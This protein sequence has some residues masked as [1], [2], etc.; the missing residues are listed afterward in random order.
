MA[1][2]ERH[3]LL[4][5][6]CSSPGEE[7]EP[8]EVSEETLAGYVQA[9]QQH[10]ELLT[11][12]KRQRGWTTAALE[13]LGV[14]YD[15]ERLTIPARSRHGVLV[16]LGR[17]L[18]GSAREGAPKMLAVPGSRRELFPPPEQLEAGDE[19]VFLCEGEPDA[20]TAHALGLAAVAVPG[21]RS[22]QREWRERFSDRRVCLVF[23]CDDPGRQLAAQVAADL[24]PVAREV[25][26]LDLGPARTNGFDLSDRVKDLREFRQ[27]PEQVRGLLELQAERARLVE[28]ERPGKLLEELAGFVRR[29]VVLGQAELDAIALWIV[30][31]H[32]FEAAEAT[33]YLAISSAEKASGKTRLLET[34][35]LVVASP[36]LTGRVTAAVLT[37]KVDAEKPTLLLDESDAAFNGE[38]E[39]AE[40][41]RGI[42]N[43][44]YRLGGR[45][46]V[47][48]P[49]GGGWACQDLSTF[50]PK[51]IAGLGV[52]PD[53]VQSRSIPIVLKRRLDEEKVQRF[54]R[55]EATAAAEA[56][57]D[58][59]A[60]YAAEHLAELAA[61]RPRLPDELG[62]RAQDVWE[63]LLA[64]A[65]LAAGEW[66]DRAR[67]AAIALS[68]TSTWEDDSLS[69]R[70][71][72]D[73]RRVFLAA[74]ADKL[75]SETDRRPGPDPGRPLGRLVRQADQR[76][77]AGPPPEAVL[78][79]AQGHAHRRGEPKRLRALDVRRCL[80]P[81]S[82]RTPAP[83]Q[84]G[85]PPRTR[86][87]RGGGALLVGTIPLEAREGLERA[88]LAVLSERQPRRGLGAGTAQEGNG[89]ARERHE[90]QAAREQLAPTNKRTVAVVQR[91]SSAR[92]PVFAF[93]GC[94][95]PTSC[96]AGCGSAAI[97]RP[98]VEWDTCWFNNGVPTSRLARFL[99]LAPLGRA[100]P[101]W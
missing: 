92:P 68:A 42:L 60:G 53:T 49:S 25:R 7:P 46:S 96:T 79:Q 9:L 36:W 90:R 1:L 30:H 33:P 27:T 74:G 83:G 32:A 10:D 76:E 40:A 35:E 23:D 70:L 6:V 13:R 17:Y 4:D 41:L 45:T 64:I 48:V 65:D 91:T 77:Q 100:G 39:Y 69:V 12:L 24:A 93:R 26:V 18:P 94:W 52:L 84:R 59:A 51:A 22:W 54:R 95:L 21:A 82:A 63:P 14:G 86:C 47:A 67:A 31:T 56:L 75:H 78:D 73:I 44:G 15:G 66:P 101:R 19:F 72:S 5:G 61:A 16:G 11:M 57:H 2:L 34:L 20:I 81:L 80:E 97:R 50:S 43:T 88:W 89:S 98:G 55:R 71:L 62:D 87:R 58:R 99:S 3:G 29:Y 85:A 37:R 8:F 38:K 28:P